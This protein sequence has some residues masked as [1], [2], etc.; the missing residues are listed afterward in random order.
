MIPYGRHFLDEQ[1]IQSVV[2]VLK[3][4]WLTQGPEIKKFEVEFAKMVG[5][6]FAVA[7]SSG[8]AALHLSCLL[9]APLL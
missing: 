6:K 5:A 7:V 9:F 2:E 3:N 4:G 1:D 8:T